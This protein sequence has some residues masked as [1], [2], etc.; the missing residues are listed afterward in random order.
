[1]RMTSDLRL[2][3]PHGGECRSEDITP[4]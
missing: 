3:E 2:R 4:G 1:V